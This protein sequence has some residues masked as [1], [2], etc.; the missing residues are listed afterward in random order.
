MTYKTEQQQRSEGLIREGFFDGDKGGAVFMGKPRS[1]VLQDGS[2]NLYPDI[3]Q[4]ALDY[5]KQNDVAWWGGS[6]PTGH[7]L[8]SQIACLNHLFSIRQDKAAVLNLLKTVSDDFVDVLTIAEHLEGYIQFEAVGGDTNFLNEGTSTRGSNCTSVDALVYALHKDGRRFLIPIEWKYVEAYGNE[9]KSVGS[10][11][12]TRKSRYL[13]LIANSK[14]L[15]DKT[16]ECCW[17][18]PFYQLMRQTLWAEQLLIHKVP[19]YEADDYLHLH[20]IPDENAELLNK[21]YPCSGKGMK[22]TWKSCLVDP[23]KYIVISPKDLWDKQE[24]DT[25][26]CRYLKHRYWPIGSPIK[27][28]GKAS[29]EFDDDER[30]NTAEPQIED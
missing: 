26:I 8:S 20:I 17:F 3:R 27:Q 9:D 29:A 23:G 5:F 24:P 19:G 1:F 7:V 11:G 6:Y 15:N 2:H 30:G 4:D 14:Y 13:D 28:I 16:L 21:K 12:K 18:E 22:E 25:D 10:K